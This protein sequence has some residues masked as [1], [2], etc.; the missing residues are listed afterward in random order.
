MNNVIPFKATEPKCS[1]CGAVKSQC[2][3]FF[4]SGTG[5]YICGVCVVHA[6]KRVE[7]ESK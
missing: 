7:E 3:H 5:K 2:K 4:E 1:F 6:K